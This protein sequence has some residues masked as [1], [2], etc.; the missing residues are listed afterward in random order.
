[1][2][3]PAGSSSRLA[4]TCTSLAPKNFP[5]SS[6]PHPSTELTPTITQPPNMSHSTPEYVPPTLQRPNPPYITHRLLPSII[7]YTSRAS[8]PE[9]QLTPCPLLFPPHNPFKPFT[10]S[11]LIAHNPPPIA[12]AIIKNVF[13]VGAT[14]TT[15]EPQLSD[16]RVNCSECDGARVY[17]STKLSKDLTCSQL[18]AVVVL[19][20]ACIELPG[21][22]CL[23]HP[24]LKHDR[25]W[26]CSS[27][28]ITA[29]EPATVTKV[30]AV[31]KA[32]GVGC[33]GS[34]IKEGDFGQYSGI[35]TSVMVLSGIQ[36]HN[37]QPL[38]QQWLFWWLDAALQLGRVGVSLVSR[39]CSKAVVLAGATLHS[40]Q[41]SSLKPRGNKPTVRPGWRL[42]PPRGHRRGQALLPTSYPLLYNIYFPINTL[43]KGGCGDVVV[44][45]LASYL[46]ELCS[47]PCEVAP[48]F[49]CMGIVPND[50][51]GR[52]VFSGISCFPLPCIPALLNTHL[53]LPLSAF[54]TSM[55]GAKLAA[56]TIEEGAIRMSETEEDEEL[57][58]SLHC[59]C[60]STCG[61]L[62]DRG[63]SLGTG[64][65]CS[66]GS[67]LRTCPSLVHALYKRHRP[68]LSMWQLC[69]PMSLKT[70][71]PL[72][73]RHLSV[74]SVV[75]ATSSLH[76]KRWLSSARI[77][78]GREAPSSTPQ[79]QKELLIT[80]DG[81]NL[82]G[83]AMS[84][85]LLNAI[86]KWTSTDSD[87]MSVP[88]DR[89][90]GYILEINREY[91]TPL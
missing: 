91:D 87:V 13:K 44:R 30:Y 37:A 25:Q 49:L 75:L 32:G 72:Q 56:V 1:M 8:H 6:E 11:T 60:H 43:L 34:G 85:S 55:L 69:L 52:R 83:R 65:V 54:K 84:L 24:M 61:R 70:R 40:V 82:Y 7:H 81:N 9:H 66:P 50:A 14:L 20:V 68:H 73:L 18:G 88:D 42:F 47:I 17:C 74:G 38:L 63:L 48:G 51:A 36:L 53:T 4:T 64:A 19:S 15:G 41:G 33:R 29:S 28:C 76:L 80:T 2:L 35:I 58:L 26:K 46:G 90:V 45:L 31:E 59:Q 22:L 10:F 78:W 79:P 23:W 71:I 57:V 62:L 77:V 89:D 16:V 39:C 86:F 3:S 5:L 67:R 12:A 27:S 21:R